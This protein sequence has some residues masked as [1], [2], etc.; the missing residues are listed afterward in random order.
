[1]TAETKRSPSEGP[2]S[3]GPVASVYDTLMREVPHG[4]WLSR[5]E[6]AIR[7]RGREPK[8]A[9]DVACGTGIATHL[10]VLRGYAPVVGVDLS[11][12]MIQVAKTKATAGG[13]EESAEFLVQ[14]ASVL[15]LAGRQFDLVISLFDS[16]NYILE[17]ERLQAAFRRIY[18]HTAPGGIFA[19]DMNSVFALRENLFTQRELDGPV[20]HDWVSTYDPETGLCH[21]SMAFW[22]VDSETG[23]E[24]HFTETHWQRAYLQTDICN[25]LTEAG[26][27]KTEVFGNYGSRPPV[28]NSDRWLF[29]TQRD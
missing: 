16:F 12:S 21:V 9:L 11:E 13:W 24:R 23:E 10:L 1:M 27:E 20:K 8:S 22:V 17:P 2:Q 15:D 4:T 25:W 18:A 29:V 6:R 19:F 26:F 28:R 5:M 7:E 14:D 3:Y